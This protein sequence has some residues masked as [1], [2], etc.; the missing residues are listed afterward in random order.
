MKGGVLVKV[1]KMLCVLLLASVIGQSVYCDAVMEELGERPSYYAHDYVSVGQYKGLTVEIEKTNLTGADVEKSMQSD[2]EKAIEEKDLYEH[3]YEGTVLEGDTVNVDYEGKIDGVAFEGGTGNYDLEIGSG[4]FIPGFE[5]QLV[6]MTVGDTID[7]NVTFPDDYYEELAGKDAVFNVTANYIKKTPEMNDELVSKA[8]DGEY[9]TIEAYRNYET[10][11]VTDE[12]E[13]SRKSEA[14]NELMTQ[15]FNTFTIHSLPEE[16]VDYSLTNARNQYIQMAEMYNMTYEELVDAYGVDQETFEGYLKEDIETSLKQEMVLNAIAEEENITVSDTEYQEGAQRYA[17][18]YEYETVE[19]FE[20]AYSQNDI[21]SSLLMNK[22]M[23]FVYDNA[24]VTEVE[25]ETEDVEDLVEESEIKDDEEAVV[26][27]QPE[28]DA[29]ELETKDTE[30]IITEETKH[31]D[32]NGLP[33]EEKVLETEKVEETAT[34]SFS[35]TTPANEIEYDFKTFRWGDTQEDVEAVEGEPYLEENMTN[36]DAHY[37]AYKTTVAGKDTL[38][39]YYFCNEGLY[40]IRYILTEEHSN[41]NLYIDDY[42]EIRKAITKKY[43]EPFIDSERW[44]DDGKKSYYAQK[45]GDALCF[46]YLTY[47]T[48]YFLD[49]TTIGMEMSADNYE[50]KTHIDYTSVDIDPGDPDYSDD[51]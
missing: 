15:L 37:I 18:S 32:I 35:E 5:E 39:A 51:F 46:G 47:S 1:L 6:G 50:I 2:L 36:V 45:K 44:Q 38:L 20:E 33:E 48:Y 41:E 16:L 34:E 7:I 30:V 17:D 27:F 3:I 43:G 31:N 8:T 49:R 29:L 10:Q 14:Y 11:K 26:V 13:Q 40:A 9:E 21:R 28:V 19:A 22:V 24:I 4:A 42:E 25:A 23:E 12:A